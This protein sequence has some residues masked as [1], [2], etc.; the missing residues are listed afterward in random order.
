M[1]SA[2][3]AIGEMDGVPRA[4]V[5]AESVRLAVTGAGIKAGDVVG[6]N[7]KEVE[8]PTRVPDVLAQLQNATDL[9]RV[10]LARIL[11]GCGRLDD[12]R[13]NP[14]AFGV[15]VTRIIRRV[16]AEQVVDGIEY[17]RVD[18][19][20]WEMRR[21]EPDAAEEIT[22]YV[23]RLYEVRNEAKTPYSHVEWESSVER[24]FAERLDQDERVRFFLKLPDWFTIDT[25][26]GLYNPDWA[27]CWDDGDRPRIH[28]VRET[29][30]TQDELGRRGTENVKIDCA[31]RHFEA[32]GTD[33]RVATSF[34]DLV[35]QTATS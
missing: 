11:N 28:L 31:K 9:T 3:K 34:D 32:L 22:R 16:L 23:D 20:T 26:V 8:A 19:A 35:T 12:F 2:I 15:E 1:T 29:K 33:Y 27:I 7:V 17:Q 10:T 30:S 6:G 4:L 21:L 18:G 14:H 13:V 24:A 5:R 25:P